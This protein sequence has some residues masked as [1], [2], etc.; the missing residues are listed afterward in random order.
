G[1]AF[2]FGQLAESES[3]MNVTGAVIQSNLMHL[4][5]PW[6]GRATRVVCAC[7]VGKCVRISLHAV[8]AQTRETL[9]QR[10]IA[11]GHRPALPHGDRLHRMKGKAREIRMSRGANGHG[12]TLVLVPGTECVARVL[13][14]L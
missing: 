3:A 13:H 1:E 10:R 12:R 14:D 11:A 9:A 7:P 2:E 4:V 5:I 6:V 8:I